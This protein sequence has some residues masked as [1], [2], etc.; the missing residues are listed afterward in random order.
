MTFSLLLERQ[1]NHSSQYHYHHRPASYSP[2]HVRVRMGAESGKQAVRWTIIEVVPSLCLTQGHGHV[3]GLHDRRIGLFH[4]SQAPAHWHSVHSA[5]KHVTDTSW[6]RCSSRARHIS[7]STPRSP[8]PSFV[9]L[10]P[11][12]VLHLLTLSSRLCNHHPGRLPLFVPSVW[13]S[14]LTS[15]DD[16]IRLRL[17][18][19]EQ[20]RQRAKANAS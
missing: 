9:R 10:M 18:L 5:D 2:G 15:P 6:H 3:S 4:V 13:L 11:S 16:H 19:H 12:S 8:W 1:S 20:L 17:P 14:L 7:T